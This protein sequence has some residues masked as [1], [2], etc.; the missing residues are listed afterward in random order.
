[1]LTWR[2]GLAS[3]LRLDRRLLGRK[4]KSNRARPSQMANIRYIFVMPVLPPVF[5]APGTEKAAEMVVKSDQSWIF[6]WTY[7]VRWSTP[8][9]CKSFEHCAIDSS[10]APLHAHGSFGTRS[11]QIDDN[12]LTKTFS[13]LYLRCIRTG[14]N[15]HYRPWWELLRRSSSCS[16]TFNW[17][18]LDWVGDYLKCAE[19]WRK[20]SSSCA[21]QNPSGPIDFSHE[22]FLFCSK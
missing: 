13:S 8:Y 15:L 9:L 3:G 1:M 21:C 18:N 14:Q 16:C 4:R 17:I 2:M 10:N 7:M 22:T 11:N 19:C 6:E 5:C 12:E 20:I